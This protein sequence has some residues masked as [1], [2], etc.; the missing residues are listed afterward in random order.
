MT[1]ENNKP[2]EETPTPETES[3]TSATEPAKT[4]PGFFTGLIIRFLRAIIARLEKTV[5]TLETQSTTETTAPAASQPQVPTEELRGW[6]KILQQVRNRVPLTGN[7]PDFLLTT[8]LVGASLA[9]VWGAVAIIPEGL[10]SS[11]PSSPPEEEISQQPEKPEAP[12]PPPE[13]REE[14][15][16]EISPEP[17]SE[18]PPA[19]EPE[20]TPEQGLIAAI[21]EQVSEITTRYA[22]G[23][24]E[25]IEANFRDGRLII[26][27]SDQWFDLSDARQDEL[28]KE[29]LARS[30]QLDFT[31]LVLTTPDGQLLARSP[32][33]GEKMVI[34]QRDN[35]SSPPN[36]A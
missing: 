20:L 13:A 11:T 32:V 7:L 27:I 25:S 8:L 18:P 15:E 30:R 14:P 4:K 1:E 9:I 29:M 33:V 2:S 22:E 3:E 5:E 10:F 12:I 28:S 17:P 31:R 36:P 34:L 6:D 16:P 21:Q 26:A 35:P 24:I 23:L 19:E